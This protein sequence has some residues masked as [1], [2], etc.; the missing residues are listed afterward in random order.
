[1]GGDVRQARSRGRGNLPAELTSFVGRDRELELL[2][3]GLSTSRLVTLVGPGGVGKTRL[4]LRAAHRL[5]R[6]FPDGTWVVDLAALRDPRL[7]AQHVAAALDLRDESGRWLVATLSDYLSRRPLLLLSD[8]CEHLIDACAALARSLL[9]AGS[10][11]RI[12][13]TSREPLGITGES[14][15][16]VPPLD[17]DG[18]GLRLF[19]DRAWA[20]RPDF[21]LTDVSRPMAVELCRRL[22]GIP[23][24]IELAAARMRGLALE[25]VVQRLDDRFTLL[26]TGD[27]SGPARHQTLQAVLDW[28]HDLLTPDQRVLWR[29]L[30]VFAGGFDAVAAQAICP[31]PVALPPD[32][33]VGALTGL[34]ERSI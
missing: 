19:T 3:R 6:A 15:I 5:R 29:R 7:L 26:S 13:A 14:L 12:L 24:A 22:D 33:I 18:H 32:R 23:L 1:M 17:A 30:A 31:D 8:N 16:Q 11:L 10:E 27:R 25:D 4:A 21:Q 28:S 9:L 20:V 34:T 2:T